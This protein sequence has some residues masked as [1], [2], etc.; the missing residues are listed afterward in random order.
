MKKILFAVLMGTAFFASAATTTGK[1]TA[2]TK[3]NVKNKKEELPPTLPVEEP[4][5]ITIIEEILEEQIPDLEDNE[6]TPDS[7]PANKEATENSPDAASSTDTYAVEQELEAELEDSGEGSGTEGITETEF[8]PQEEES[9]KK[10][11]KKKEIG[12]DGVDNALTEKYRNQYL[13]A[14]GRKLLIESIQNSAPYRPYII[15]Q[16]TEKG[17]PLYLQYL[18][19]VESNYVPTAVSRSGATGIWQF[20]ENSMKPLLK[21][22][23]WY[24]DRRDGWKSTDMA[25]LKLTENYK[26]FNDWALALAAY[27]CGAGAMSRILKENPGKDFWYLAENGLL[28][29]QSSQY[30][31]RLLAIA[32]IIENAEYYGATDILEANNKILELPVEEFDYITTSAMISFGQLSEASGVKKDTIK[33][34]NLAL[35]RNCTPAGEVYKVMMPK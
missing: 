22:S 9:Q 35:F 34:L 23:S 33:Q 24:D 20:M 17:L 16:L 26:T 31:P 15:Q 30:V 21:K 13:G 18:P 4:A 7:T 12:L 2:N 3:K 28:N 1:T 11:I 29:Q 8:V 6:P 32:D 25:I 10:G 27:N 19:I 5:T 14:H